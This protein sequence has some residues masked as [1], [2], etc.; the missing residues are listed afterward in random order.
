MRFDDGADVSPLVFLLYFIAGAVYA[1]IEHDNNMELEQLAE[2]A[3]W[4]AN[5]GLRVVCSSVELA[6]GEGQASPAEQPR[7]RS[8]RFHQ[9]RTGGEGTGPLDWQTD[10]CTAKVAGPVGLWPPESPSSCVHETAQARDC[11]G[12]CFGQQN[13]CCTKAE[14][15]AFEDRVWER[16]RW[17]VSPPSPGL[18]VVAIPSSRPAFWVSG[19]LTCPSP[20]VHRV[21]VG[22]AP[23][24][25]AALTAPSMTRKTAWCAGWASTGSRPSIKKKTVQ[26]LRS[27]VAGDVTAVGHPIQ[28]LTF[29]RDRFSRKKKARH[30]QAGS[31]ELCGTTSGAGCCRGPTDA[32]LGHFP[33]ERLF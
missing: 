8:R 24:W 29:G 6:K 28:G 22:L 10:G 20:V 23:P 18:R 11:Q 3:C 17:L 13:R 14:N 4:T 15:T 7:Q 9:R 27:G 2:Q 16:G 26:S 32:Q 25:P 30:F 21:P 1:E 31:C 19:S 5:L 12:L 33:P